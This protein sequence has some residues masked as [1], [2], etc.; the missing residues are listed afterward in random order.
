[1]YYQT[2]LDMSMYYQTLLDMSMY[3]QTLLEVSMYYQTHRGQKSPDLSSQDI[4][5]P[6]CVYFVKQT[7]YTKKQKQIPLTPHP[8]REINKGGPKTETQM[9]R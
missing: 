4:S 3:Y 9:I 7:T 2:M 6:K 5:V 1:M 8:P